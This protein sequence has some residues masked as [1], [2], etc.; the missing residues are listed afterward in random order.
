MNYFFGINNNIYKSQITIPKFQNRGATNKKISLYKCYPHNGQ[1]R[2]EQLLKND[3]SNDFY[4]VEN[5]SVKNN[6]VYF[7]A[8]KEDL[9][10][11]DGFKLKNFNKFSDTNHSY[12]ANFKIFNSYNKKGFSSYQSE[13][14]FGMVSKQSSIVSSVSSICNNEANK[15]YILL[16]NIYEKAIH[17]TFYGFLV[18][19]NKK[20]I[21][22]KFELKTNYTNL[23]ELKNEFIKPSIYFVTDQYLGIPVYI[24]EKNG[25]LSMEHTHPPHTYIFS[26]DKFKRI[27]KLKDKIGKIIN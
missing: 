27:Q 22:E 26:K 9:V 24:S 2:I 25:H 5:D 7:L 6:E 8:Y 11:Y 1:W 15:N 16:K 10:G 23:L 17:E 14:P 3:L 21:L 4:R 18:D 12:R 20:I 13:Y 19:I